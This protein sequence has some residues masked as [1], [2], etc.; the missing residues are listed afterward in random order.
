MSGSEA[1]QRG[2][3]LFVFLLWLHVEHLQARWL[4]WWRRYASAMPWLL[5][6]ILPYDGRLH[7][8]L[9]VVATVFRIWNLFTAWKN[10]RNG[11]DR[12]K[13]EAAASLTKVQEIATRREFAEVRA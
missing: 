4:P 10:R 7:L 9:V 1:V 13:A 3:D 8:V 5:M 12:K 11:N 6:A 2:T